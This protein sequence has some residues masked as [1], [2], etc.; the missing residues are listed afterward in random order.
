MNTYQRAK[1]LYAA[2][3]SIVPILQ[4]DPERG[5]K[6]PAISWKN[7][8]T[9]RLASNDIDTWFATGEYGIGVIM[10]QIS[11]GLMMI[12]LEG[13]AA[14]ALTDLITLANDSGLADLWHRMFGW[15]ETT[16]TGGYHW[17][18]YAPDNT[19]G[20]RKLARDADGRVLAETRENG[21]YSVVAPLDGEHF[22]H[23]GQGAWTLLQG[24]PTTAGTFTLDELDDLLTVFRTLDQTPTPQPTQTPVV[25]DPH[26][27]VTP[28]DDYETRTTWAD[29]LT[30]HGWAPVFTRGTETFWRRP[31]KKTGISA[32]TGHATDRDRLYV[33]STS[34]A[35]EA[36][37]PYTKFGAYCVAPETKILTADLTWVEAGTVK[38]GD[39][40]VG[41]DE[42]P[43]Q[44]HGKRKL[45]VATV[46][47]AETRILPCYE[48]E[49][50]NGLKIVCT[51]EHPWLAS[52][53]GKG[54][55]MRWI[56]TQNLRKGQ[57]ISTLIDGTWETTNDFDSGWLSG[58]YD[59]EGWTS[60]GNVGLSQKDGPIVQ[61]AIALLKERGFQPNIKQHQNDGVINILIQTIGEGMR[62][63]GSLQPTRLVDKRSWVGRGAWTQ[64]VPNATVKSVKFVGEREVAAFMTD[65]RTFIAEGLVSHNTVLEHGGNHTAAAKQL[66]KEGYG[67]QAEHPRDTTG[68]DQWITQGGTP[69]ASNISGNVTPEPAIY[70]RTD[71]GNALRFADTYTPTFKYINEH[72]KW[73][74]WD[75]SKWDLDGGDAKAIEAARHL[76]RNLPVDD[77]ADETHRRRSL[78]NTAIRA[79]L[80]LARNT[81]G[82]YTSITQYDADPYLLN[83]PK[84]TINLR[85]GQLTPPNPNT[86]CLRSTTTAPNPNCHTPRWNHFLDQIFMNDT[87]L[88]TYIQRFFGQAIIGQTKEQLLPF[89]YG[90]GA[91]GKTTMLN[92]IQ[93]I[94]GTGQT[95]YSTTSPAEILTATN[96]HPTEIA[97][98]SGVRLAVVS[99]LEEG[100]RIA[101]AKTKELTGGDTLT[102]RFMGKDFFTF[103]PTHTIVALTNTTLETPGG[104]SPALWRRV[105]LIPFLYVVPKAERNPNLENELLQE[106][107][108]ILQWLIN[109]T[110]DYLTHGL[111]DP[112]AVTR[113]TA[114]YEAD[115]NTVR[116]FLT[117]VCTLHET[118]KD[119]FQAPVPKVRAAY[120]RWCE[121]NG[122]TPVNPIV[123]GRRMKREGI[124]SKNSNTTRFYVGL[125]LPDDSL[126]EALNE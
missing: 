83:T 15:W 3:I 106:A 13:K 16:P 48:L 4:Y 80:A 65:T 75:G 19:H 62:L 47:A 46:E 52:S 37:T 124:G 109:G 116:Q 49:L 1:E 71:D 86:L 60:R 110:L 43:T 115:Q 74:H 67:R 55:N 64:A 9:Q 72:G 91:N 107:P 85:T 97:A 104:G 63:L 56:Q 40:L 95:G 108:G 120:E 94:L 102:A 35:F 61:K 21:G 98:L 121:Q 2:G 20:N 27:G 122:Y 105:R 76:A 28:G 117:E 126:Q 7:L 73:A 6:R 33:W 78:S 114:D 26:T 69:V 119:L 10:G 34:T 11:G 44:K 77:K 36:E 38:E 42:Y 99:E 41:I 81:Q 17:Y 51:D 88:I 113:A 59:G 39:E 118:N 5:D 89:F 22:H 112:A 14:N 31:G 111:P 101:E 100:Q 25:R 32:S 84:G 79:M 12:E 18:I 93:T 30:P 82:I 29:I 123:F 50:E 53:A 8:Q 70:T 45:R 23:T 66:A 125:S 96:R 57:R 58:M 54:G 24:G 68:L 90:T 103:T 87:H 92:V